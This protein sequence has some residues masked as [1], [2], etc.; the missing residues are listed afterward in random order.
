MNLNLEQTTAVMSNDQH[1]FLIAGAGSGKTRVIVER[2]KRLILNGVDATH[3]LCIT[4]TNKATNEMKERLNGYNVHTQTFH[5]YCYEVLSQYKTFQIFEHNNDFTDS[6]ILSIANYKNSL[7]RIKKP[8]IYDSYQTYLSK[9]DLLDFDDLMIE[10][11]DY[12]SKHTYKYIFIDEFQDTNPL[13]YKLLNLMTHNDV[14]V[15]AV[16]D[17]DQSIYAFRGAQVGLIKRYIKDYQA[18]LLK[19]EMN[20]RSNH[21]VLDC[22]NHLIK[23]NVN[24]Y[25][26]HLIGTRGYIKEPLAFKGSKNILEHHIIYMI[27]KYKHFEAV[28]LYRNHYQV[29]KLKQ[30][31]IRNYLFS[32]RCMSFHESKGLEFKV[33]Y[34][35]GVE[36]LPFDKEGMFKNLEEERRLLFVGITRAMDELYLFTTK[37][38]AFLRQTKLKIIYL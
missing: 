26:K 25:K 28:I 16:G 24:R 15:F 21:Y 8:K 10:S 34:I 13:Q 31:L 37:K 14:S 35:V 27:K 4:F 29:T 1:I 22:A 7:K 30:L 33:V 6:Q 9:R 3:I 19:L 5:G 20:Y 32:V 12:I 11:F 38:T 18:R 36:A 17:P 2:I 23:K